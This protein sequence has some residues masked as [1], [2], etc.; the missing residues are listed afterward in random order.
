MLENCPICKAQCYPKAVENKDIYEFLCERCGRI[1][2]TRNAYYTISNKRL[3]SRQQANLIGWIFENPSHTIYEAEVDKLLTLP[4]P[5]F[6]E[7][8]VKILKNI[9]M[10]T[11]HAGYFVSIAA[12]WI[13]I[14]WCINIKERDELLQHLDSLGI[15]V[16]NGNEPEYKITAKGWEYLEELRSVNV[17]SVQC[18]VAMWFDKKM[19]SGYDNAISKG[20]EV[21]GYRPH[22]V[23]FREHTGKIDD[24]IIAQIKQS[25]FVVA[26]FTGHRGGVYF[27]AGFAKGLGL[28]VIWTCKQN[29][30]DNLHFDIRQYNCIVWEDS[31][32]EEFATRLKNRIEAVIGRGSYKPTTRGE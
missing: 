4:T 11:E 3:E 21:A 23:S 9:E 20:I 13:K 7:R 2:I 1:E 27:E 10:F 16:R 17:D 6:H 32:L 28:E 14:G 30:I 29:D 12:E 5:R 24:E 19:Q 22:L 18:F 8:A 25:R 31:K 26:D 15:I